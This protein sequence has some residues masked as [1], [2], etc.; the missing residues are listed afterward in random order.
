MSTPA[1]QLELSFVAPSFD[2]RFEAY[3]QAHPQIYQLLEARAL[4]LYRAG[5]PRIG[6]KALVEEVRGQVSGRVDNTYTAHYARL[7]ISRH[8][9]LA[10]VIETRAR[11]AD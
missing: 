3:H 10:A 9:Q 2:A 1:R 8:P 6:A 4:Q 11:K 5:M 7:L